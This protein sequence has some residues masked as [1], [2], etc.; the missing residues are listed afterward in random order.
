LAINPV[1][2]L[3]RYADVPSNLKLCPIVY[4]FEV[5]PLPAGFF[6]KAPML[7]KASAR[8]ERSVIP[9]VAT[10]APAAVAAE[11]VKNLRLDTFISLIPPPRD[12]T[13]L[14]HHLYA[15]QPKKE[16]G[17]YFAVAYLNGASAK[18]AKM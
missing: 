10:A 18:A 12:G 14:P 13:G 8:S 3:D 9:L 2:V 15:P 16:P 4:P 5:W 17:T 6:Q 7:K 11:P 1:S